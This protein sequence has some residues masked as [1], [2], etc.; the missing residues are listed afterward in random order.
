MGNG[1]GMCL[2][3][4]ILFLIFMALLCFMLPYFFWDGIDFIFGTNIGW[5]KHFCQ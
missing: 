4:L 3:E 5:G 2:I 1:G